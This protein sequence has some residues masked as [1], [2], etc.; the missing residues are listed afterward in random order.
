MSEPPRV[1]KKRD[2]GVPSGPANGCSNTSTEVLWR[3]IVSRVWS[4]SSLTQASM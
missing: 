3:S 2:N 4:E 1:I